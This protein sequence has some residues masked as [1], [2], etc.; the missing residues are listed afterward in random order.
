MKNLIAYLIS[1][2]L[3]L[4]TPLAEAAQRA[5]SS[6]KSAA[7]KVTKQAQA[8]KKKVKAKASKKKA[9]ASAKKQIK[10]AKKKSGIKARRIVSEYQEAP[11]P[12]S[13]AAAPLQVSYGLANSDDLEL[14]SAAV[15]V[16]DQR[17]GHALYAKNP[18]VATPIASITK[19]MTAI[20]VL[21]AGLAMS[22]DITIGMEDVDRLKYTGSRLALGT[23]LSREELLNLALIASENRAAAALSRAYPGGREAF[24]QAMN[25]KAVALG[26]SNTWFVDGTGLDSNNRS[27]AA[28]LA[29]L[30]DAAYDYPE[31]RRISSTGQFGIS[32]PGRQTV[33]VKEHGRVRKVSR[34]VTRHVAFN[35]TNA[36]TRN[37]D[38]DIGVSKTGY[39]NEAGHCLVMQARIANR[40]V[41]VV[42]LDSWGKLS[43][44]GDASR[45]RKWLET[46]NP[47]QIAQLSARAQG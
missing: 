45:V 36:L 18:D 33:K 4:G 16:L 30:V 3:A 32:V 47:E 43:R 2:L 44:I 24:I 26:M 15:M 19:L 12:H 9:K 46:L 7:A 22:E 17:T 40:P 13:L 29:K 10:A 39:I 14:R 31:I 8:S 25:R 11:R 38:W 20:V 23:T 6:Q 37:P 1:F 42:L 41:I 21:D 5:P 28:D 27:T 34:E 35:N